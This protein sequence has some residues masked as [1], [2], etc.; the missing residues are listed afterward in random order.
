MV[1]VVLFQILHGAFVAHRDRA[2]RYIWNIA[3]WGHGGGK[4]N[5][6]AGILLVLSSFPVWRSGLVIWSPLIPVSNL[7]T[8][9]ALLRVG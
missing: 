4:R 9:P 3:L 2:G 6:V 5:L 7:T 8:V 1:F